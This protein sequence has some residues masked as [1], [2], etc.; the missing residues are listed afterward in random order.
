M[1]AAL[2]AIEESPERYPVAR[3]EVRRRLLDRFPYSILYLVEVREIVVI[4]CFHGRRDPTRW[5]R[6]A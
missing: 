3:G 4:A 1:R 5:H 2:T 6:R